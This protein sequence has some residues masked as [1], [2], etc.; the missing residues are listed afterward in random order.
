[1]KQWG[2]TC[3]ATVDWNS[4]HSNGA[5]ENWLWIGE[6]EEKK[7]PKTLL[8]AVESVDTAAFMGP[9]VLRRLSFCVPISPMRDKRKEG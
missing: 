1:M 2:K 5:M 8:L 7:M 9:L 4:F 6:V 3:G